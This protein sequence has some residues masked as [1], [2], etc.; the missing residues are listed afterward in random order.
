MGRLSH[1]KW[2]GSGRYV[3]AVDMAAERVLVT[4]EDAQVAAVA[5]LGGGHQW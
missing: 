4:V 3:A 5:T 2:S 1:W